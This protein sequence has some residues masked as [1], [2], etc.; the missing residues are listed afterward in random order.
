MLVEKA[1]KDRSNQIDYILQDIETDYYSVWCVA[2]QVRIKEILALSKGDT[3]SIILDY[4]MKWEEERAR[5][6]TCK[7]YG[8]CVIVSH[9]G[10]LKYIMS[11]GLLYKKYTLYFLRVMV[12]KKGYISNS[13][14]CM[15]GCE[16]QQSLWWSEKKSLFWIMLEHIW[17]TF[18]MLLY[19][20]WLEHMVW[21]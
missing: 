8:K 7:H 9:G 10:L 3:A 2:R 15:Q 14:C 21:G 1:S 6:S 5:E 16:R 20:M 12:H 13:R 11:N 4:M 17:W 18:F 19:V